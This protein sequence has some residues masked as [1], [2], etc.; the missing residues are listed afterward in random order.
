MTMLY[1]VP[2]VVGLLIGALG[3][4][5]LWDW[6]AERVEWDRLLSTQPQS[7]AWFDPA[8]TAGLPEA[9]RR[10]FAYSIAPG[11]PLFP[12]AEIEMEGQF[13]LKAPGYMPMKARQILA[14]PHGFIWKMH[15][16]GGL[17]ISGSD[18]GS[19]TRFRLLGLVPVAR[20]GGDA[21]H[22]RSAFGRCVIEAIFW[23]PAALLPR[24]GVTWEEV[25]ENAAR[26]TVTE[27]DLSQSVDVTVD[28]EG[29]P[30]SVTMMRW[31]NAN[32]QKRFRLQPF[33]GTLSDFRNVDGYRLPFSVEGGNMFGTDEYFPF[34][35]AVV[36]E[37]R[38]PGFPTTE[39]T[40]VEK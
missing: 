38:F 5:R 3:L 34:Y 26:V 25:G 6:N 30:L 35:K 13:S 2:S 20:A 40:P 4:L 14:L 21:D 10:Y 23:T 29:K 18:T 12:I 22:A 7:P 27:G 33:G 1:L 31:S 19:W 37:I 15:L 11:T 39:R 32:P 8:M 9:A 16:V 17:P 28:D 36:T 24:P